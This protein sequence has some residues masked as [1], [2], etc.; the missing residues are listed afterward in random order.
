MFNPADLVIQRLVRQHTPLVE[1]LARS[2]ARKLPGHVDC[3]DLIQDGQLALIDSICKNAKRVTAEHFQNYLVVRAK[4]A[5]LDGLRSV[6]PATRQIRR[7]MRRVE[8]VIQKLGHKLGRTPLERE[9]A[10]ELGMELE[11][12][13]QLL[14]D[15]K[16][17]SLISL[18][19]LG[20]QERE[21]LERC[22]SS[23]DD[24]LVVLERAALRQSL[25]QA[26][27]ALSAQQKWVL[28]KY[29]VDGCKM[30]EI[31]VE[32]GLTEARISQIHAQIIATLRAKMRDDVGDFSLLKPRKK[33]REHLAL[34]RA[35]A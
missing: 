20:D 5:M 24:P 29:Y 4:G 30:S 26:I 1:R 25:A 9:V 28:Q 14:Q 22:T 15:T 11:K 32:L 21:F 12:Y 7:D 10:A 2:L 35:A 19:D 3:D 13:Q 23:T 33:Q 31:G 6:D 27:A 8:I 16:G 17:Y 18:E 34:N